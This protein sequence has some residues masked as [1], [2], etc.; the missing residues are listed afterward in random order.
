M[1]E[2]SETASRRNGDLP[3]LTLKKAV[4]A[5]AELTGGTAIHDVPQLVALAGIDIV[6]LLSSWS[7]L[8]HFAQYIESTRWVC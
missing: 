2:A 7:T 8:G 1:G 6:S 5:P 4:L 3:L